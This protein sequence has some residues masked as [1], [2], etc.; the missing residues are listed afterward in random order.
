MFYALVNEGAPILEE[1][2]SYRAGDI[3]LV[4]T[5]GYGFPDFRG[6]PLFMAEQIGLASIVSWLDDFA[7]ERG[8]EYGDWTAA[9]LLRKCATEGTSFS[10]ALA[11]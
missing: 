4:W 10:Q 6:G 11:Q 8:N 5:E 3:E 1:G 7:T 2:I 9:N